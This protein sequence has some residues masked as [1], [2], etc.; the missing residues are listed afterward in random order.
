MAS[1]DPMTPKA[2]LQAACEAAAEEILRTQR[3]PKPVSIRMAYVSDIAKHVAPVLEEAMRD[4][5]RLEFAIDNC[6]QFDRIDNLTFGVFVASEGLDEPFMK[7]IGEGD[8]GRKALDI[9]MTPTPQ[10]EKENPDA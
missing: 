6:V 4:S 5:A 10:D 3:G 2:K 9:A 8:D 7:K 1:S